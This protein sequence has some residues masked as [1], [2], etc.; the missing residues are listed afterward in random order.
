MIREMV[1]AAR[2][3]P[4]FQQFTLDAPVAPSRVL[5]GEAYDQDGRL[6]VDGWTTW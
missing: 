4:E 6:V 3:H 2:A 5:L 1:L